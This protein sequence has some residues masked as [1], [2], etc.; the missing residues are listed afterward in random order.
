MPGE[1]DHERWTPALLP[2]HQL[3]DDSTP[4][5]P[6]FVERLDGHMALANAMA[7]KVAGITKDTRA[8]AVGVI[9]RD[10]GCNPTGIFK[11]AAQDLIRKIIPP[12]SPRQ[13]RSSVE[14]A[15]KVAAENGV[16]SAQDMSGAPEVLRVYEQL[17]GKGRL[18]IRIS[19]HQPLPAWKRLAAPGIWA[20]FGNDTLN[21]IIGPVAIV[22]SVRRYRHNRRSQPGSFSPRPEARTHAHRAAKP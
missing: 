3:I 20:N 10:A 5:N 21:A 9:V 18:Q 14:A 8:V 15:Q 7:M 17:F 2:T 1:W 22:Q 4:N 12:A 6:V 19:A 11:D 16:T 13:L